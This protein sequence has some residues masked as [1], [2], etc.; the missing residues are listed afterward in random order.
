MKKVRLLA[1]K[2]NAEIEA[3]MIVLYDIDGDDSEGTVIPLSYCS[4]VDIDDGT[5]PDDDITF[6]LG[7]KRVRERAYLEKQTPANRYLRFPSDR[8]IRCPYCIHKTV[9]DIMN[10]Y[11][12]DDDLA[13]TLVKF[14]TTI[15][16]LNYEYL[17]SHGN[18]ITAI[19]NVSMIVRSVKKVKKIVSKRLKSK[20]QGTEESNAR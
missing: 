4:I 17:R 20:A 19:K 5:Y 15:E 1:S 11:F 6:T 16:N 2:L 10:I 18:N 14:L 8:N 3:N 9:D 12:V 13:E 7:L